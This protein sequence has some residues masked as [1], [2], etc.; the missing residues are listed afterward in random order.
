MKINLFAIALRRIRFWKKVII[1]I[2]ESVCF[3]GVGG[4]IKKMLAILVS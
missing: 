1:E 2:L 3:L 4:L